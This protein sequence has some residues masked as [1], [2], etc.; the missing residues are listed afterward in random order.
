MEMSRALGAWF[1]VSDETVG[2][3]A[4]LFPVK[5]SYLPKSAYIAMFKRVAKFA[6]ICWQKLGEFMWEWIF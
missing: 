5:G 6:I 4:E 3:H 1:K 2:P